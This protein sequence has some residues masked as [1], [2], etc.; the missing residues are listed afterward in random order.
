MCEFEGCIVFD[1]LPVDEEMKRIAN[2]ESF[3][4]ER[5]NVDYR[6]WLSQKN[7]LV[8]LRFL[9]TMQLLGIVM[10]ATA[11]GILMVRAY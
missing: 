7:E 1:R 4:N 10:L 8:A 6:L 3:L 5:I 9:V 2:T 11:I